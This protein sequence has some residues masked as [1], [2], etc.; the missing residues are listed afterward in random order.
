MY[1]IHN[2]LLFALFIIYASCHVPYALRADLAVA[3]IFV[4]PQ[5]DNYC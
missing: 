1:V 4:L 3:A 5:L 2:K